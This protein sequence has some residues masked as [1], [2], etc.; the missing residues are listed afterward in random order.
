[1]SAKYLSFT[2]TNTQTTHARQQCGPSANYG[3]SCYQTNISLA[4]SPALVMIAVGQPS[5]GGEWE[6][7]KCDTRPKG[8]VITIQLLLLLSSSC[9]ITHAAPVMHAHRLCPSIVC[10]RVSAWDWRN[11]IGC[12]KPHF[13]LLLRTRTRTTIS[14]ER[15]NKRMHW[16]WWWTAEDVEEANGCRIGYDVQ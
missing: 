13:R 15:D 4:L 7:L 9:W 11:L 3:E 12:E 10:R 1:M 16:W 14:T 2:T 5:S 6:T 8:L